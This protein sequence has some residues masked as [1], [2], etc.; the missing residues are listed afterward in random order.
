VFASPLS[1]C[2]RPADFQASGG[3]ALRIAYSLLLLGWS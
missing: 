2:D 3:V 1:W